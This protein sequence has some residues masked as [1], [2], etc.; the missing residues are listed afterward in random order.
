MR[1]AGIETPI[2]ELALM[3]LLTK[4]H[5]PEVVFEIGT[6]RGRTALNFALNSPTD[7]IVY[8]LD[9]PLD[10]RD[11]DD[12]MNSADRMIVGMSQTGTDYRGKQGSEKIHQLYGDSLTFDFSSYYSKVDIVFVD[13]AHHYD[14]VRSD[15]RNAIKMLR[16]D[17]LIIWHDFA[18]YGDYNDVVRAVL[19]EIPG[20]RIVQIENTQ[21]AI[22]RDLRS[23][24]LR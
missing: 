1:G 7:C 9:L 14:V 17:G 3:A 11:T 8:T 5:K 13:G 19:H 2:N 23:S 6:F 12:E 10:K 20:D 24:N 16:P 4:A 18:N 22:Y 21:L 15:T